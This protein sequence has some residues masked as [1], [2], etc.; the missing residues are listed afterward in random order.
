PNLDNLADQGLILT[1]F[2]T[3]PTCSVSRSM[4]V[5]GADNHIAGLGN[6][7][8]TIADNQLGLPG[9]EG[10]LNNRVET[11][12]EVLKG[13]RTYLSGKWH[14]GMRLEQSPSRRGFDQSFSPLYGGGSH[15]ADMAGPDAHRNPLLYRDN[16]RLINDLPD[17]FFSTTYYTDRVISQI[18]SGIN[19]G[20][21]FFAFLS[22][23]APHW[24]LQ[25]PDDYIDKY[26]GRYDIG[27]DVIREG[28]IAKQ[29][30]LGIIPTETPEVPRP[31]PVKPWADLDAEERA[32]HTRNMEI[33][34]A[35]VDHMDMS[36]GRVLN[37]LRS[38]GELDDTMV[39]FLSD[40]G[41]EGWNYETAP[42][43][44][45]RFAATFDNSPE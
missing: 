12:A 26:K 8:E 43:P 27:Y 16:G 32:F 36:I 28:R 34:A 15:F 39:V 5:S 14:L 6:M 7:A 22:Y 23:T 9:Y 35:M 17:D 37:Y 19:D 45:G 20:A 31:K 40:N 42:P 24:P 29:K 18:E 41:A 38:K 30:A 25:A 33:Y 10:Y 21:P 44:V 4:L 2:Y 3:G 11:I 1:N 13:Y